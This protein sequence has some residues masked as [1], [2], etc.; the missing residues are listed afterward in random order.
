MARHVRGLC[1]RIEAASG[2]A[3]ETRA[4]SCPPWAHRRPANHL[5]PSPRRST[6]RLFKAQLDGGQ[7]LS[8]VISRSV[9][10]E[11]RWDNVATFSSVG[12]TS[13]GRFKVGRE[14]I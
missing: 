6:Y 11:D 1:V 2:T 4:S 5:P 14:A 13:D 10:P 3:L 12:P 8:V 9:P 7:A